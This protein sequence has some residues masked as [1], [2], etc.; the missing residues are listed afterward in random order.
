MHGPIE[1]IPR[2]LSTS[3]CLFSLVSIISFKKKVAFPSMVFHKGGVGLAL[4]SHVRGVRTRFLL[5]FMQ[6]GLFSQG[7]RCKLLQH[8]GMLD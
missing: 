3:S 4:A 5:L 8:S 1:S 6:R 2:Y 7:S